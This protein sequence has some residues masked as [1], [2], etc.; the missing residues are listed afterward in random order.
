MDLS[1]LS[2]SVLRKR[3]AQVIGVLLAMTAC[4]GSMRA[5]VL[6]A[7][8]AA[9]TCNTATGPG[10]AGTI[11]IKP[12][13]LLTGSASI[14][15]TF[16]PPGGGLTVTAPTL[17]TLRTTNQS[18]GLLYTVNSAA[19]C[20][21]ASS[22][23]T[24][25]TFQ[26]GGTGDATS[27][28]TDTVTANA[29]ALSASPVTISC[30]LNAGVYTPGPAQRISVTSAAA[31][32][33][34]FTLDTSVGNDPVWLTLAP[35]SPAGTANSTPI[36]FTVQAAAGC[37]TFASSSTHTVSFHLVNAPAP[38][39]LILVTLQIVAP[40]PLTVT[41]VPAAP[42]ISLSYTKGSG[43]AATANVS[44][45]SSVNGAFFTVNT[46]TLPSWLTVN[47]TSGTATAPLAFTTT[48]VAESLPPG[49]YSATVYLKVSGFGD[50]P[51][52]VT[53][54]VTNKAPKLSVNSTS[55]PLS[56][57]LGNAAPTATITA[58]SN[59]SPIQYTITTGGTLA[60]IVSSAQQAGLAYSFGTQIGITFNPLIFA[61][62]QP[63]NVL[64]G[65]VTFTWGNPAST[66]VVTISLT[67]VSPGATLTGLSPASLPTAV[68]GTTFPIVLTGTGFVGG[69][70]PTLKTKVGIVAGGVIVADT[71]FSVNVVNP[72]NIIL[73]IVVPGTADA[74]LPFAPGGNGGTVA[75]GLCNGTCTIPTGTA[76]LTIGAGPIIQGVTSSS[77]FT[78][79]TAPAIPTTAPYDMISIFGANFCS[80]GGTGCSST[81]ILSGGPDPLTLRYPTTLS[82]D[83]AGATQRLLSVSFLVHG[84]S[85]L[86]GTAPLL[87]ATNGQINVIVPAAVSGYVGA[88]TVDIVANFGYGS[89]STL[90]TS[91]P[92]P[93]NIAATNPGVFTVGSDGQGSAAALSTAWALITSANPTGMRSTGTDSDI[94]QLY[95][96][97]L[98][99]PDST[100]DN[101][102][103]GTNTPI[104]D[105][106]AAVSGSGNYMATLQAA[107]SVS[108]SLT[109]IDGAVIQSSLLNTGRLPP[110]LTTVP[111]VTVGGVAGTV[112]YAA[113]VADTVAGLYQINVQLPAT[114]GATLYPFYPLTS[115]P[116]TTLT[117][118]V[119]LPVQVT[120]GGVTSQNN[121]TV[122]VAPRLKVTGPTGGGLSATVGVSWTGTVTATEGTPAYR[123][124]VTS[125]VLPAGLTLVASTGVISGLPAANTAGSYA[126]TVTATDAANIPL[127]GSYS[128][129]ITVAGGLYVTFTGASPY[130]TSV[131]GSASGTLTTVTATG[132]TFPYT[133]A[134]TNPVTPPVGMTVT[135][136]P[137]IVATSALTPAG[138]YNGV[139]VTA[140]DSS[141]TPLTGSYTFEL[142]VALAVTKGSTTSQAASSGLTLVTVTAAGGTGTIVY[143]LDSASVTAGLSINSATGAVG[144][145]TAVAG[146][147]PITVTATDSVTMAPG[148]TAFGTGSIGPFNVIVTP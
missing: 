23:V 139:V 92:F 94:I 119:Q 70:D 130:T 22:G 59:D 35:A 26:A 29:S 21:G 134:I 51:V 90:L 41:P 143:S 135:G 20:V 120:V 36:A 55:L 136:S 27:A 40:S 140:T 50:L 88:A 97:G 89:G 115:A 64:T 47:S 53:L 58:S 129:V 1:V 24:T 101:T 127:T 25:V 141:S 5:N 95:V 126:V 33:T 57:T 6:T 37:G 11:T 38:D 103:T 104:T 123:Y 74:N 45:S 18:A 14:V 87:F 131:F 137:G 86:I 114:T 79:V 10:T 81:Q 138:I 19:G 63:G 44:V 107:T 8:T 113:F 83:N 112:T 68:S 99:V 147:Y 111:T 110:C 100:A 71:N 43:T 60:P 17:T 30:T 132:G 15:V 4:A 73:T 31:G 39:K 109:T 28:V 122:W 98:G 80:S 54:L 52:P 118:P 105:C 133:L 62:A 91:T 142:D 108:P 46:A 146:T 65:T 144:T 85:T 145:G 67:V 125:G 117:S 13:P 34:P 7:T 16:T 84:S 69:T 42:S 9:V 75:L 76:T 148:A 106:I 77:A 116:I 61:T 78:E 32:G 121:V 96:T 48:G 128:F 12:F 93:V 66:T 3:S 2:S 72:S 124:A 102:S 49:T 82:P 56:W